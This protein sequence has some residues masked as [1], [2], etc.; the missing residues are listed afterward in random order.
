MLEV[1][2]WHPLFKSFNLIEPMHIVEKPFP[3]ALW[4][5]YQVLQ[6][7]GLVAVAA[8]DCLSISRVHRLHIVSFVC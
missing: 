2:R 6:K 3:Q 1:R 4:N 8:V 7:T 5:S